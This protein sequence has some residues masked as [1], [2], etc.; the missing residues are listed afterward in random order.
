MGPVMVEPNF[1]SCYTTT[2]TTTTIIIIIIIIIYLLLLL[3]K[4]S[5]FVTSF[6]NFITIE[7]SY[8]HWIWQA[9]QT[10]NQL[11]NQLPLYQARSN[12]NIK[13]FQ[14]LISIIK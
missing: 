2:T 5:Q 11:P 9:G 7:T 6:V 3:L 8:N 1:F 10:T 14:L 13:C 4:Y 12:T